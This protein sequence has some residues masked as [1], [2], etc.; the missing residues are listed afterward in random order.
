MKGKKR[1][2]FLE[3]FLVIFLTGFISS[4]SCSVT[5]RTNCGGYI[6]M[7]LSS[8]T[9]AHGELANQGNYNYVLC[10][11]FGEGDT[12]C[13]D[14]DEDGISDNKIVGLSSETNAHA[15]SPNLENYAYEVCYDG[16]ICGAKTSCAANEISIFS[17]SGGTNAHL[18]GFNDYSTKICCTLEGILEGFPYWT[19][20]KKDSDINKNGISE[21]TENINVVLGSTTVYSTLKYSEL[22]E[23]GSAT[24][25]IYERDLLGDDLIKTLS[26]TVTNKEIMIPWTITENDLENG[27]DLIDG[28]IE[29]LDEFYFTIEFFDEFYGTTVEMQSENE[30]TF[31]FEEPGYCNSI[32][33]CKN[34]ENEENCNQDT[35]DIGAANVETN[36]PNIDCD[37]D[38]YSCGCSWNN[39]GCHSYW[40][41]N[42]ISGG[43]DDLDGD[44]ISDISDKDI[45]GDGI[46]NNDDPDY[47]GDGVP[48]GRYSGIDPDGDIDNDGI[49][50]INDPDMDGDGINNGDDPDFDGDGILDS[51][52][53][54]VDPNG[55]ID[56]DGILNINDPDM[57]GDG[58]NNGDDPDFDGNGVPDGAYS[59]ID[60]DG[61][62]D[63][64]GI[65]NINDPD[66]D[67]DGINN[68]DDPDFDGD[69]TAEQ[70]GVQ[71]EI[72]TGISKV[73]TC[74]YLESTGDDCGDGILEYSWTAAWEWNE[75]NNFDSNPDGNDYVQDGGKWH[76]DPNRKNELCIDGS[77]SIQCP[78][79]LELPFFGFYNLIIII[80]VI[81]IIYIYRNRENL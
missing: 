80:L 2:I 4:Q 65:L 32:S 3:I 73:G 57:D 59:G 78:A 34:Y 72:P 47:D 36:N 13:K 26:G 21:D 35:C 51:P 53:E 14:N 39:S 77:E 62:I 20:S 44:G 76:Y 49:L 6:V 38:Y 29:D 28:S 16:L 40:K 50:N 24:V 31:V 25:K 67:G 64:D 48:D 68:G 22:G 61:D 27:L 79:Q 81:T 66:M 41:A 30:L 37:S 70:F 75:L 15:E 54:S 23:G 1:I 5:E 7:G 56:G 74:N 60:P 17:L 42:I 71:T 10:C 45:D 43:E 69:G 33:T 52:Y 58:I 8:A 63:E 55:D 46:M 12:S 18:G 11:D 19:D 9:N